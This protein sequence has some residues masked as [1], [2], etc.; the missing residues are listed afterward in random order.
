M[1][2]HECI[3]HKLLMDTVFTH[4]NTSQQTLLHVHRALSL[5]FIHFNTS[6]PHHIHTLR[7]YMHIIS[8]LY[9]TLTVT[10][11]IGDYV[12]HYIRKQLSIR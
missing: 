2:T 10:E 11:H 6:R 7:S 9:Y 5:M 4:I 3:V 8:T 1:H 12:F